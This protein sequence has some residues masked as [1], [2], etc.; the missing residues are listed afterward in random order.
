MS[1]S[2]EKKRRYNERL[3]YISEFRAW[4]GGAPPKWRVF[5]FIRW[6]NAMPSHNGLFKDETDVA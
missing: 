6:L 3:A 1:E 5:S 2:R 4:L